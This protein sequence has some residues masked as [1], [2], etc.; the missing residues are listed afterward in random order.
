M[1]RLLHFTILGPWLAACLMAMSSAHGAP[2]LD[3]TD[4]RHL[5]NRTGFGATDAEIRSV[6]GLSREQAANQLLRGALVK[7]IT[8][9]PASVGEFV[10]MRGMRMLDDEARKAFVR[11]QFMTSVELRNWWLQEMLETPSPMTEHMTLF[12]H[13]HFV[14]S[15]QKVRSPVLMFRQNVLLRRHAL[16]NF[17]TLLHAIARDPAMV[18]YL[19]NA[20]N[21]KAQPNENFAREVMELFTLG[22]GNYSERDIKEAAR[23]FTGWS[24][25]RDD[26]TFRFRRLQHDPGSKTV[27]GKTGDLDGDDV[28][29]LLLAQPQCA[30]FIVAKLWREFIAP[31]PD[32]REVE[33]IAAAFFDAHYDIPTAL[34]LLLTSDAF[35]AAANRAVLVKSPVELIVGTLRTFDVQTGELTPF[36]FLSATLGQNLF[37]PPN[38]KGW[39]GGESWINSTTLL[40]P[41]QFLERLFRGQDMRGTDGMT[42]KGGARLAKGAG[43]IDGAGRQRFMNA[44][45]DIR[46]NADAWVASLGG[47]SGERIARLVLAAAP[48]D[49]PDSN[50]QGLELIRAL[51]RDAVFQL[52]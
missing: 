33:R 28:L 44:L 22:E 42:P 6:V 50:A 11:R 9:A 5:L 4:A 1:A 45:T 30:R 25:E 2:A 8:P 37:A 47:A 40:Q 29:D 13:N 31:E 52:K 43:S 19:D 46:F 20:Q 48:V 35:Y 34:R 14:S 17:A 32:P 3:Y 24:I 21:R 10:S 51:T 41:K 12:W 15:Q 49:P 26:G 18:I 36:S 7:A 38:V 39:P 27:F 16:G 23:A